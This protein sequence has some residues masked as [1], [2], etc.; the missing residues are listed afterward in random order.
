MSV[1]G[2]VLSGGR[3]HGEDVSVRSSSSKS[4]FIFCWK[5]GSKAPGHSGARNSQPTKKSF[6]AKS[7]LR[8]SHM[9]ATYLLTLLTTKLTVMP[10]SLCFDMNNAISQI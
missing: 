1:D 6:F 5:E 2:G 3:C 9:I 7:R 10:N 8:G 4:V